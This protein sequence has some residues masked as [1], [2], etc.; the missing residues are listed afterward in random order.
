MFLSCIWFLPASTAAAQ[1]PDTTSPPE[2]GA[3]LV[4]KLSY[5]S[6]ELSFTVDIHRAYLMPQTVYVGDMGRLTLHIEAYS[7]MFPFIRENI[8]ALSGGEALVISRLEMRKYEDVRDP[9]KGY[10]QLLIDFTA[11]EPGKLS[12][13]SFDIPAEEPY[14]G[15]FY[16]S[17]LSVDIAS[18]LT[19]ASMEISGPVPPLAVPGTS[20]LFYG[21]LAVLVLVCSAVIYFLC[22]RADFRRIRAHIERRRL[23]RAMGK[24]IRHIG[25][26]C[27]KKAPDGP[28]LAELSLRF[29]A[30]MRKTLSF[31]SVLN[32]RALTAGE[33]IGMVIPVSDFYG[34]PNDEDAA[35]ER[36]R[37]GA[38]LNPDT[39]PKTAPDHERDAGEEPKNQ[40]GAEAYDMLSPPFL[41]RLFRRCDILR[42]SGRS[43]DT[44]EF[45]AIL[46]KA[47]LFINALGRA[48]K[49][50]NSRLKHILRKDYASAD[51]V[52]KNEQSGSFKT[53]VLKA[54]P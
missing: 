19:S 10:F 54:S 7:G 42:F 9:R 45:L 48:E 5:L 46:D 8:P 17:G 37:A 47:E 20:F 6:E 22:G 28:D 38:S 52:V 40:P 18:I 29:S 24:T 39:L 4:G 35:Q 50:R 13:P 16:V 53:P 41:G 30:E 21:A 12:I 3:E 31:L 36:N 23:I 15:V 1:E 14:S 44:A 33:L 26:L 32:C 25:E 51:P 49:E 27:R 11:Y 34:F 43:M 2:D